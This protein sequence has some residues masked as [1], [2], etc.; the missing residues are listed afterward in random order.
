[1]TGQQ[2][3]EAARDGDAAKFSTLLS[4]PGAQSFINYQ[5]AHGNTP[6]HFATASGTRCSI[7]R[8]Q[9]GMRPS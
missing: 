8:P 7:S 1:M 5:D 6:L 2:L 4:T 3:F 9:M